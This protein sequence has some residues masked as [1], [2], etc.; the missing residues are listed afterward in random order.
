MIYLWK[1]PDLEVTVEDFTLTIKQK[2]KDSITLDRCNYA[3]KEAEDYIRECQLFYRPSYE[4]VPFDFFEELNK[5]VMISLPIY[6]YEPLLR[7]KDFH[8]SYYGIPS[9]AL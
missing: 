6:L 9:W 8:F 1:E 2:G 5:Y 7:L 4:E 3:V